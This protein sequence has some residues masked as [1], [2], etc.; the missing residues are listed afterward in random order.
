MVTGPGLIEQA[1]ADALDEVA[2]DD[3]PEGGTLADRDIRTSG[4]HRRIVAVHV[5]TPR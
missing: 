5:V 3:L 2:W 4:H 1:G